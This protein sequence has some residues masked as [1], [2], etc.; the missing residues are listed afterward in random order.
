MLYLEIYL[1]LIN[2]IAFIVW[3]A[4]KHFAKTNHR[5]IPEKVL[6][7]WALIGGGLGSLCAMQMVRHKTKHWYFKI[8]IPLIFAAQAAAFLWLITKTD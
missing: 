3:C 2:V 4:D 8:G 6:F 5:R 1:I 7:F